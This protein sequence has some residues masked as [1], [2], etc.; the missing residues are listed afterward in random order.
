MEIENKTDDSEEKDNGGEQESEEADQPELQEDSEEIKTVTIYSPNEN[1]DGFVTSQV[2]TT[3]VTE[4]WV[5]E[6]LIA[7]GVVPGDV[8]VLSCTEMQENGVNSLKLDLNQSLF[9]R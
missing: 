2:E 1:A 9:L 8:Q 7:K 4:S 3:G 6:Q 5:M